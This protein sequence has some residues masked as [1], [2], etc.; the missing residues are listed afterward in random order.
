MIPH[1]AGSN[2]LY[3]DKGRLAAEVVYYVH[4]GVGP[5]EALVVCP[6]EMKKSARCACCDLHAKMREDPDAD[7]ETVNKLKSKRRIAMLVQLVDKP[8]DGLQLLD[9]AY[10]KSFGALLDDQIKQSIADGEE[11]VDAYADPCLLYTSDA[12]DE[13]CMV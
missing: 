13:Q 9:Q 3:V 7:K 4:K 8:E 11:G 10:F 5:G 2:N 1:R 6:R 12:A